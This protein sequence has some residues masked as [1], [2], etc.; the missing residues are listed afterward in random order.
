MSAMQRLL[1]AAAFAARAHQGQIRK[2]GR[3][4][5]ISHPFRVCLVIR[6]VFGIDDP[7]VLTAALLHDT[8][9]DTT[10]DYD[11]II[12]H[13]G[14]NVA[15]WVKALTKD[16]RLEDDEREEIYVG[17]LIAGGWQV[18]VLKLAD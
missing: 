15:N 4:P 9:E 6:T 16:K 17:A 12:E 18:H 1:E 3:T 10:T 2:D 7:E 14:A 8:I 13:F 11:D 5:Y